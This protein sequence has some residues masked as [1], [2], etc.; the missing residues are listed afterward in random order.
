LISIF[1]YNKNMPPFMK[2]HVHWM[3]LMKNQIIQKFQSLE[4]LKKRV[5]RQRTHFKNHLIKKLCSIFKMFS[6]RRRS[7]VQEII[8]PK[9]MFGYPLKLILGFSR[10]FCIFG[11][12]LKYSYTII[13]ECEKSP[14][15]YELFIL[16]YSIFI[17]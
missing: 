8:W 7:H 11:I 14:L 17:I 3:N 5:A 13:Y 10:I 16:D 4:F 15:T 6:I 2:V 1:L 9:N 12:E